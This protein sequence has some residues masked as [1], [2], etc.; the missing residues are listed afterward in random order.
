MLC[1]SARRTSHLYTPQR[2]G[3]GSRAG[4]GSRPCDPG[5]GSRSREGPLERD[6]DRDLLTYL[7]ELKRVQA[8]AAGLAFLELGDIAQF[9]LEFSRLP[10]LA[11][12]RRRDEGQRGGCRLAGYIRIH[13][14][15]PTHA[16]QLD[17][18]VVR[19]GN[20]AKLDKRCRTPL[21]PQLRQPPCAPPPAQ[22]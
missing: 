16:E 5:L 8:L 1:P 7:L 21:R 11:F 22:G 13:I 20:L 14:F 17:R 12:A 3:L 10:V 6:L 18:Q 2:E 9:F 19:H 4:P 15:I